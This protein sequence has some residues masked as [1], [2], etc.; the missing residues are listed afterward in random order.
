[1]ADR[2]EPLLARGLAIVFVG[3]EPG[4]ESLRLGQYY[5]DPSNRFYADLNAVELTP[6][7]LVPAEY[8]S[9]VE[10]GV[11]LDDVY[12]DPDALQTRIDSV[13]PTAVCFNSKAALARFA[14]RRIPANVW[15]GD[16]ARNYAQIG[17][18]EIMWAVDD[19]SGLCGHHDQRLA[20]LRELVTTVRERQASS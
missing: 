11:G 8:P 19:S 6:R 16:G 18:I 20:F 9:L 5:A 12:D 10:Y 2:L 4:S 3:T 7:R 17:E 1:M 14:Q 13:T 15:R